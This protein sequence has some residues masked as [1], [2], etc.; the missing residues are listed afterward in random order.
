MA[1]A[2]NFNKLT[3]P[4]WTVTL[5][6]EKETT[7]MVGTP[8]KEFM[9]LLLETEKTLKSISDTANGDETGDAISSLYEVCAYAMSNNKGGIEITKEYL[10]SYMDFTDIMVFFNAYMEFIKEVIASKN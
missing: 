10:E 3:K 6:D 7:I 2:L 8:K 1:K 5:P 9:S 4:Y